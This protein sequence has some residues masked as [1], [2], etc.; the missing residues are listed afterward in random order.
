MADLHNTLHLDLLENRREVFTLKMMYKLSLNVMN[1]DLYR[2]DS[3]GN[4]SES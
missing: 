4:L 2:P 3:V 1:I